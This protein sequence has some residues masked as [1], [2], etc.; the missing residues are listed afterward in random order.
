MDLK[1]DQVRTRHT[2]PNGFTVRR[3]KSWYKSIELITNT[4]LIVTIFF[5]YFPIPLSWR[6]S[7]IIQILL[8]YLD[9]TLVDRL[10]PH[11]SVCPIKHPL[12]LSVSCGSQGS[13]I[14]R[15]SPHK[16]SQK[17]SCNAFNTISFPL[18]ISEILAF[19]YT[20]RYISLSLE[21]P[22]RLP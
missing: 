16:C 7:Y 14:Q 13:T 9:P 18:D 4:T 1:D 5:F 8:D 10:S 6:V 15:S 17:S 12:W 22:G 20:Q 3:G 2:G 19:W 11:L 21:Y